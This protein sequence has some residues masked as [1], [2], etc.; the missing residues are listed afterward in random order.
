LQLLV[1]QELRGPAAV[2]KIRQS[3]V[4]LAHQQARP[5]PIV[6]IVVITFLQS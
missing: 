1:R 4:Q 3:D 2:L 5:L 6:V